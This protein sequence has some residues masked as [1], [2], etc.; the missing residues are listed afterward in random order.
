MRTDSERNHETKSARGALA[1]G[2]GHRRVRSHSPRR[3]KNKLAGE[4]IV[5]A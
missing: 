5:P 4:E 1:Q 3:R 2:H